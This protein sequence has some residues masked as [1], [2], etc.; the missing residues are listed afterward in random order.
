MHTLLEVPATVVLRVVWYYAATARQETWRTAVHTP[1]A[2]EQ[3]VRDCVNGRCDPNGH[4]YERM[5]VEMWS[6][7]EVVEEIEC[8]PASCA[9][10]LQQLQL[11]R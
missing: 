1:R 6:G 8:T 5:V 3:W 11:T 4:P 7:G 2:V 10:V 9:G